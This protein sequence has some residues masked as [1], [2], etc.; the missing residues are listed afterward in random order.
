MFECVV[1]DW[2]SGGIVTWWLV[3]FVTVCTFWWSDI[4]CR[5]CGKAKYV[6]KTTESPIAIPDSSYHTEVEVL[7]V[8]E[9]STTLRVTGC[10]S[11]NRY[12]FAPGSTRTIDANDAPCLM[13]LSGFR[14]G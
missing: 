7:V 14:Y 4:V 8:Y 1:W 13:L 12:M 11:G 6:S 3:D 5:G 10:A 2:R 9:G